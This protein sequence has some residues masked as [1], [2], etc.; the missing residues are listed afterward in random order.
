MSSCASLMQSEPE[1]HC[2]LSALI[3]ISH[4][5]WDVN[6]LFAHVTEIDGTR[7]MQH[8]LRVAV[9]VLRVSLGVR[10]FP[11]LSRD[12]AVFSW[13]KTVPPPR[14]GGESLLNP[15]RWGKNTLK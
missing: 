11:L 2:Y 12:S 7:N 6:D 9:F 4:K 10:R 13:P 14:C 8:V 15:H 3:I 5:M 1:T